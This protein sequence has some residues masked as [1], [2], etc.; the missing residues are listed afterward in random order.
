MGQVAL[1]QLSWKAYVL[2]RLS[3]ALACLLLGLTFLCFWGFAPVACS[4]SEGPADP[5]QS[6][7][8]QPVSDQIKS[9]LDEKA[10]RTP[11]EQKI[12]SEL[13][14]ALKG[15]RGD[16]EPRPCRGVKVDADGTI[17]VEIKADVTDAVLAEIEASPGSVISSF[18][19]YQTIRARI[20]LKSIESIA[21]LPEVKFIRVAPKAR[22]RSGKASQ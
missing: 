12:S 21:K 4:V 2:P 7:R 16:I 20:P 5:S 18:P 19:E 9:I 3:H 6:E 13:L 14:C 11:V 10:A 1:L 17:L 8:N 22:T 15:Q